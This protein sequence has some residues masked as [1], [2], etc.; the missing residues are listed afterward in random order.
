MKYED[1]VMEQHQR[2]KTDEDT[3]NRW[4]KAQAEI[5]GDIAFKAGF[6][7][8]LDTVV[9]TREYD[10]GKIDGIKEVVDWLKD[11]NDKHS[12]VIDGSFIIAKMDAERWQSKL[13]E[14]GL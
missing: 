5:T 10:E 3:I 1:T 4:L 7:E 11:E 9:A 14:W 2:H 12:Q 6:K 13:K 8:S